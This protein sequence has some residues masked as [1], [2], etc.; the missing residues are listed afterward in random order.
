MAQLV[1][2]GDVEL[3]LPAQVGDY[4]DAYASIHH[5][6]NVGRLFRPDSPLLPNYTYVPI[7]Y[8][9]RASSL[10]VGG[11][12]VRR[13]AGQ[14]RPDTGPPT[15]G[16]SA[17]LDYEVELGALIGPG[18]ALG[19]PLPI[20]EAGKRIFGL[21]LV[22]DWSARDIQRWEYQPLGPFLGKSFATSVGPWVVTLDALAPFRTEAAPRASGDPPPLPYLYDAEDQARGGFAITVTATIRSARMRADGVAALSLSRASFADM[23]W[24]LAQLVAHHTSNGCNL[25]PGD[26]IAS[27]TISGPTPDALG[28]LLELT[29][30]GR[31]PVALPSGE[32][33][34]ALEDGDEV[35][36]SAFC[37]RQGYAHI[38]FGTCVGMVA[39]SYQAS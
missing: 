26:L 11:T 4:S 14:R 28:C 9:G 38:G 29:A 22:N 25:R 16:P 33:R 17:N 12:P 3:L 6:T 32:R 21:C 20:G 27:G 10:V 23:Y 13:P 37:E 36:L 34:V 31:V 35:T 18:N 15:F 39:A 19:E 1:A 8:H 24:T 2:Q 5:A 7:M 30:G